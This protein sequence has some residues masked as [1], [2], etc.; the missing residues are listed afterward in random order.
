MLGYPPPEFRW[1]CDT[2]VVSAPKV[3]QELSKVLSNEQE[4]QLYHQ[5][6]YCQFRL[7]AVQVLQ[8]KKLHSAQNS[9]EIQPV[10][11]PK[12]L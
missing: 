9:H 11:Y 6:L 4:L 5:N 8:Y 10:T 3:I 2:D 7:Q 1:W 12:T